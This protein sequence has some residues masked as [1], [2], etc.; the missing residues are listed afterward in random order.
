MGTMK[1]VSVGRSTFAPKDELTLERARRGAWSRRRFRNRLE[2]S[3]MLFTKLAAAI[4]QGT[5]IS[6]LPGEDPR[7]V[8]A[9]PELTSMLRPESRYR[10]LTAAP[11]P[12]RRQLSIKGRRITAGQLVFSMEADKMSI[13]DTAADYDLDPLAVAEAV[14]YVT[15]AT[16][17]W[18]KLKPSEERRRTHTPC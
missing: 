2:P 4:E 11:H 13:A 16:E 6:F 1:R 15:S 3:L 12:W 18:W 8:D 10:F 17:R 14:D 7:A 9:L 5:V